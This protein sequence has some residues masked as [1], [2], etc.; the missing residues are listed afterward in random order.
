MPSHHF[1]AILRDIDTTPKITKT[2][3]HILLT[4]ESSISLVQL[5]SS[6][7]R[8]EIVVVKKKYISAAVCHFSLQWFQ[9]NSDRVC[10]NAQSGR[11]IILWFLG[12]WT[13]K[14]T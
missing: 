12:I 14:R 13:R 4:Y 1:W 5:H 2:I 9:I 6:L 10:Q 3:L 11:S 8:L 7:Q